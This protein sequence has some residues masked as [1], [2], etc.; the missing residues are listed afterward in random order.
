MLLCHAEGVYGIQPVPRRP[1]NK[2]TPP[3]R[4]VTDDE[5]LE[6]FNKSPVAFQDLLVVALLTGLRQGDL[7]EMRRSQLSEDGM[8]LTQSK[9]G[10]RRLIQWSDALSFFVN[11]AVERFH[12]DY[13]LT[14]TRG[15]KWGEWA[16]QSSM[17]RLAV[18]WTFHDIRAKAASDAEH[19]VLGH[20]QAMLA[21]YKR[22]ET[23]RP[24][25]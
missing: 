22:A 12:S 8:R 16:I 2:E 13:V 5:F 20:N 9:D 17:R 4:Y 1:R 11:R 23:V 3:K 10:K 24:L 7:R 25:R 19:N 6:A 21:V 14:N 18:D 15:Q